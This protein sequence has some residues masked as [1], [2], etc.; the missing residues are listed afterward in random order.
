LGDESG[1]GGARRSAQAHDEHRVEN[2]RYA[3]FQAVGASRSAGDA[4]PAVQTLGSEPRVP[5]EG[6]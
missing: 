6:W 2:R 3:G 4:V 5:A 1:A